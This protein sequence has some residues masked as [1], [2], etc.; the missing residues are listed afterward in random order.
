MH[1]ILSD[2][3]QAALE[4]LE[5]QINKP[6]D[7]THARDGEGSRT[8]GTLRTFAASSLFCL[9]VLYLIREGTLISAFELFA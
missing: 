8:I 9:N 2:F 4:S 7:S 1:H 6:K 5:A 3:Y